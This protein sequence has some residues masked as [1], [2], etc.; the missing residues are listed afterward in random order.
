MSYVT[1]VMIGYR[2]PPFKHEEPWIGVVLEMLTVYM[3]LWSEF[4]FHSNL[5]QTLHVTL[6]QLPVKCTV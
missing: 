3:E 2:L 1:P 4:G 5:A 6:T